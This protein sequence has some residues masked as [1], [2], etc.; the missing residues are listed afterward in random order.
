M[1]PGAAWS[2]PWCRC[3]R[4]AVCPN[5]ADR[6]SQ[7]RAVWRGLVPH[8]PSAKRAGQLTVDRTVAVASEVGTV[9]VGARLTPLAVPVVVGAAVGAPLPSAAVVSVPLTATSA[10]IVSPAILPPAHTPAF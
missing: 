5:V 9:M 1:T 10:G 7:S 2:R 6:S 8:G 3:Y 4:R